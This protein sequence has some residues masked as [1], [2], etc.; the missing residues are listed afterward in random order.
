MDRRKRRPHLLA[1][2]WPGRSLSPADYQF[3]RNGLLTAFHF[4]DDFIARPFAASLTHQVFGAGN[5]LAIKPSDHVIHLEACLV[6]RCSGSNFRNPAILAFRVHFKAE[7]STVPPPSAIQPA[8][9][10]LGLG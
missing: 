10:D 6:S 2:P 5:L 1:W 7:V 9:P 3:Q 4:D 8:A